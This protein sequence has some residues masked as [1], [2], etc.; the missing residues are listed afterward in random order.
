MAKAPEPSGG[1]LLIDKPAG[2]TSADV[3]RTLRRTLQTRRVGHCGTLDPD[4]TGLLVICFSEATKAVPFLMA[5]RKT[6]VCGARLGSETQTDD[7]AGPEIRTAEVAHV[8]EAAVRDALTARQGH[9][10]QT[11]PRVSALRLDGQRLHARVR[12]GE[13]VDAALVPRE[14]VAYALH[15]RRF[16]P[17]EL[18][19]ELDVGPG[20]YVR[21]LVRDLG[22]AVGSAAHVAWLRRTVAGPFRVEDAVAPDAATKDDALPLERALAHLPT[23]RLDAADTAR[24]RKGLQIPVPP[25]LAEQAPPIVAILGPN[26]RLVAVAETTPTGTLKVR[27]GFVP[28]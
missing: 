27:R 12:R 11:P 7:A 26:D 20:Y 21:S 4:A 17:P 22:R 24:V 5:G 28:R 16:A 6:Y 9:Q 23:V 3:V 18:E 8:T 19:L 2:P 10:Q 14:V 15:L 1:V 13:D 25:S